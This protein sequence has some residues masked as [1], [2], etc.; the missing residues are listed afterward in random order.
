MVIFPYFHSKLTHFIYHSQLEGSNYTL[1]QELVLVVV[2]ESVMNCPH[3][4][5][6][7]RWWKSSETFSDT[8]LNARLVLS[9]VPKPM[10]PT[11]GFS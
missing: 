8:F 6:T 9:K 7:R 11:M 10:V 4:H 5:L 1:D 2:S 3:F